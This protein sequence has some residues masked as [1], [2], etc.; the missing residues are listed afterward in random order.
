MSA[1]GNVDVLQ[2]KDIVAAIQE[3]ADDA[4]VL[5]RDLEDTKIFVDFVKSEQNVATTVHTVV[6]QNLA[7]NVVDAAE[8]AKCPVSEKAEEATAYLKVLA[9]TNFSVG[10]VQKSAAFSAAVLRVS[11]MLESRIME[12][13]G[14]ADDDSKLAALTKELAGLREKKRADESKT[15]GIGS[16]L[17]K[18]TVSEVIS[19][20]SKAY[21]NQV[22]SG[23]VPAKNPLG[24]AISKGKDFAD[25]LPDEEDTSAIEKE[26]AALS[27]QIDKLQQQIHV[28]QAEMEKAAQSAGE[29]TELKERI[30]EYEGRFKVVAANLNKLE[31]VP[32]AGKLYVQEWETFLNTAAAQVNDHRTARLLCLNA[33]RK[34]K[35]RL[36]EQIGH[37]RARNQMFVSIDAALI[38]FCSRVV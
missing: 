23:K 1:N 32:K 19:A 21:D 16:L 27:A 36:S 29:A 3:F 25:K 2:E 13:K 15:S 4:F 18:Q 26:T 11:Q 35:L 37:L 20:G 9:K 10:T 38:A 30:G 7:K 12:L 22:K 33:N 31:E 6:I 8:D 28:I 17:N 34:D 5:K 14:K 24:S